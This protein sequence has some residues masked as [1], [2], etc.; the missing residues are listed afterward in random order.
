MYSSQTETSVDCYSDGFDGAYYDDAISSDDFFLNSTNFENDVDDSKNTVIKPKKYRILREYDIRQRMDDD[1]TRLSLVL[2]L[3]KP[4]ASILLC[5]F[6]WSVSKVLEA[7]F[8]DESAVREK[9]GLL[10]KGILFPD[11]IF[12]VCGICFE[13]FSN[14]MIITAACGH[15]YCNHCWSSYIS[16][17][18]TNDGFRCLMLRCPEPSC[19]VAVSPRMIDSLVSI[20][21]KRK[22]AQCLIRSY[23]EEKKKMKWCPGRDCGFAIE[24]FDGNTSFDVTCD[25]FTSFCWNCSEESHR[26]V[27]CETVKKW[28]L[29]NNS[30][31]E[32]VNYILTYCKPCPNCKRPIEKN[33]GCM[34][35]TC[36]VCR[37]SFCWLCLSS[38]DNHRQC[39]GYTDNLDRKKEMARQSLEKYTHY[40][41]R[42]DANRR[43]K[44]KVFADFQHIKDVKFKKLSQ[45]HSIPEVNLDFITKAWL[46]VVECRRVLEWSYAYGYYL[47]DDEVVKKQFFEYLQGEAEFGL[48]K[49]HN[50]AEKELEQFL[51][52]D[53]SSMDFRKFRTMLVGLTVVTGNYFEKLVRALENGLS[54]VVSDGAS[55]SRDK[56][57]D[58]WLCDCCSYANPGTVLECRMCVSMDED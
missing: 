19:T 6:N 41:E 24:I 42:W 33:E 17:S 37:H 16:T 34:H 44:L 32:N 23:V 8:S 53:S 29:K 3:P 43:S 38:Y 28:I 10:D 58:Y 50:C 54:D 48:E 2:S 45:I 9:V 52:S 21:D 14:D 40:F 13:S 4:E 35:M 51:D 36:R 25:C 22:Y 1:I 56:V 11:K 18:I 46:Q 26:P 27:D 5:Y 47:P 20:D 57:E 15:P 7:W 30:E 31:S 49:L 55:S 39:N 12:S